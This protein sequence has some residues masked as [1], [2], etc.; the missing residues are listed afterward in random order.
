MLGNSC[1]TAKGYL[2]W[3][4]ILY[5]KESQNHTGLGNFKL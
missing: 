4:R 3:T 2:E 5:K 1:K